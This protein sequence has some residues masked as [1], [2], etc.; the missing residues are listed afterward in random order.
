MA[1]YADRAA[2]LAGDVALSL[3]CLVR[4]LAFS[5][6]ADDTADTAVLC[7]LYGM[8]LGRAWHCCQQDIWRQ[9]A[10]CYLRYGCILIGESAGGAAHLAFFTAELARLDDHA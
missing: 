7:C 6:V 9:M 4:A 8:A 10:V 3:R 5:T 2:I 1:V